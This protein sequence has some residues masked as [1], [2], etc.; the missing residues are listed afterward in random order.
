ME[1]ERSFIYQCWVLH[2]FDILSSTL[3]DSGGS[4]NRSR[5]GC[6][7]SSDPF[8]SSSS[9]SFS[10]FLLKNGGMT[11]GRAPL[12]VG[13][14]GGWS[15]LDPPLALPLLPDHIVACNIY[16]PG[17]LVV[18]YWGQLCWLLACYLLTKIASMCTMIKRLIRNSYIHCI[19]KAGFIPN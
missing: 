7:S 6:V 4:K 13:V 9:S 12:F 5:G 14:Q 10:F 15:P 3:P 19:Y 11:Q 16:R 17:V 18:F 2:A 1:G 8:L